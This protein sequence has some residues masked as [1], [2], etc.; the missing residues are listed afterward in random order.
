MNKIS[1]KAAKALVNGKNMKNRDTEVTT[2]KTPRE[3]YS[4]MALYNNGIV[5]YSVKYPS[6][7]KTIILRH[8]NWITRTTQAR[9]NA[10]L[11]EIKC[12]Y[13]MKI[14][15]G[16]AFIGKVEDEYYELPFERMIAITKEG[17]NDF[18]IKR[19][20]GY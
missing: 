19:E 16:N 18:T 17:E 2:I 9:I 6:E 10:V 13:Y 3:Q 11:Q 12:P 1:R 7:K 15:K 14:R 5:T 4:W 8:E 20:K